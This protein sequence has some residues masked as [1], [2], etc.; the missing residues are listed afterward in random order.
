M[1]MITN[2]TMEISFRIFQVHPNKEKCL[3]TTIILISIIIKISTIII[4]SMPMKMTALKMVI[5]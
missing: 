5:Y 1:K 2:P 3:S 4:M